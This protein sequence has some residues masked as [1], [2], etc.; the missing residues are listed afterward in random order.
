MARY[1]VVEFDDNAAAEEFIQQVAEG[2]QKARKM[3]LPWTK[4]IAGVFVKPGR[5]CTCWNKERINYG[6]K[7]EQH[8]IAR[9]EKFGWWVCTN[10]NKPR[11]AGHQLV[12]QLTLS[13][14]YE[15][16]VYNDYEFCLT[17]LSVTGIHTQN[18]D[19][20]K[21]LRRKKEK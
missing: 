3:N 15:G 4:R 10:C 1:V 11:A 19:R 5:T 13:N 2:N 20:P 8:G 17:E 6:D 7:N 21:K 12:N 9:G 16:T 14:T 18:I